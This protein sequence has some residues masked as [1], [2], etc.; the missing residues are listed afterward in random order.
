MIKDIEEVWFA[1][2]L[3]VVSMPSQIKIAKVSGSTYEN[4]LLNA[5]SIALLPE[6]VKMLQSCSIA[7]EQIGMQKPEGL[8]C[9]IE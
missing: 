4:A 8:T 7:F 6:A 2:G 1:S 9:I 3:E 5:N